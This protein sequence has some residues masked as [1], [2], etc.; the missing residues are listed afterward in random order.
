[1]L[2]KPARLAEGYQ[3]ISCSVTLDSAIPARM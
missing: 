1:M 2:A 3:G